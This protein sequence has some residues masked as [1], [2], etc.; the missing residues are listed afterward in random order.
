MFKRSFIG[1][2]SKNRRGRP[3]SVAAGNQNRLVLGKF[4]YVEARVADWRLPITADVS[5]RCLTEVL[6]LRP[7]SQG[8]LALL[9]KWAS[10][11]GYRGARLDEMLS[12]AAEDSSLGYDYPVTSCGTLWRRF[13]GEPCLPVIDVGVRG[14]NITL[15]PFQ[16]NWLSDYSM[17]FAFVHG[18]GLT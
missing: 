5:G 10:E 17:R 1:R 12:L 4:A 15:R 3:S 13:W 2:N 6:F 9:L 7:P 18:H 16:P 14:R 8:S 11:E